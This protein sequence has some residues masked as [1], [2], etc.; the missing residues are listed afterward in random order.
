[1]SIVVDGDALI[2]LL[3]DVTDG[4]GEPVTSCYWFASTIVFTVIIYSKQPTIAS[5][6][7]A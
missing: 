3:D 5:M 4:A 1:M 6:Q 2:L 7:F